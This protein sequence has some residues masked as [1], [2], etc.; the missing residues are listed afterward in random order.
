MILMS[1][2]RDR[3]LNEAFQLY[4]MM[5]HAGVPAVRPCK[6]CSGSLP[7]SGMYPFNRC[8]VCL[9]ALNDADFGNVTLAY[10]KKH[11]IPYTC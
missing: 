8:P 7:E 1:S 9:S 3:I 4:E 5:T 11:D 2:S 6:G 10:C